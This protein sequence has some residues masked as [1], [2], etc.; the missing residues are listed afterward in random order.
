RALGTLAHAPCPSTDPAGR[1][2][3]AT[4][5]PC[6]NE[7]EQSLRATSASIYLCNVKTRKGDHGKVIHEHLMATSG[8][9]GILAGVFPLPNRLAGK[10]ASAPKLERKLGELTGCDQNCR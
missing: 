7:D 3:R 5:T 4:S 2:H 9:A 1:R 8:S 10:D 6:A